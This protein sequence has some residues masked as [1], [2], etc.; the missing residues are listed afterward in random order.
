MP[1]R[2]ESSASGSLD[3]AAVGFQVNRSQRLE[4]RPLRRGQVSERLEVVT[5]A[6]GPV[7]R[8]G[9]ERVH[10]LILLDQAI[11]ESE[12]TEEEVMAGC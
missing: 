3:V 9:A 6:A 1:R 10:E 7:E 12:Q 5:Q 4:Q 8:P 11:L 2:A